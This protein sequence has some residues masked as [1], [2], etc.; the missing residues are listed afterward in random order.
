MRKGVLT[1]ARA[2]NS[3]T[4]P[5]RP[6]GCFLRNSKL[7]TKFLLSLLAITT[8]LT[9]ATLLI[10]RYRVQSRVRESI[11]DDLGHSVNTY[12][13]FEQQRDVALTRSASLIANLPNV[14]ALMT[15]HDEATIQDASYDIQRLSGSDLLVLADRTG[16]VIA[17][18]STRKGFQKPIAQ[19]LLQKSIAAGEAQDF[20]Y[21]GGY[22]YEILIQPIDFGETPNKTNIGLLVV[23][24]EIDS[25]VAKSFGEV[26]ASEVAFRWAG[27]MMA[28]T[29]APGQ[30]QELSRQL[31]A[32]PATAPDTSQEIQL[33]S[34]RYLVTTVSLLSGTGPGVSLSVLR[35]F[36]KATLFLTQLNR[37]LLGLGFLTIAVGTAVG[38]V[39]SDTFT[40]P[41][42]NLVA[43]VQALEKGNYSFPLQGSGRDEVAV[44]TRA[45]G[46]MRDSLQ[47][48]Q[49][50]HKELEERLR[51][52]HKMEAVG[53]LAGGVAHDFNNLLTIIRGHA[54]LLTDRVTADEGSKRNAQQ[55]QKATGRAVSMTRQLL[56]FS[57]M[58]VLQPRIL[59][60]NF[61]VAE[62]GKMLP[63]LIGENI[64]YSFE[65]DPQLANIKADPSQVEQVLLNPAVNARDAMPNGGK[66][67]VKT[68]NVEMEVSAAARRPSMTPGKYV[69]L[70]V[71]DTGDGMDSETKAHIFE[72]FFTTKEVG[73]GT[74]LGLA[75]VYGI[76]KQSG[77]FIWVE[78]SPGTGATFEI[79]FPEESGPA[80][81]I[82]KVSATK[83]R[84]RGSET[85]L[86]VE[87]ES[88][89][90]DL[91]CQ[92]LRSSGYTVL[93]AVDGVEAL[94]ISA[95]YSGT[96]HLLLS[97]MIMPRMGG[98]EL[99]Q[100]IRAAR[101]E[102]K[103]VL[104]SGYAEYAEANN[105]KESPQVPRIQKP[106][107]LTSLAEKVRKVLTEQP[108]E[109]AGR[110]G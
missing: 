82:E 44:V 66:L 5:P 53:R 18:R 30:Q 67:T 20:W 74:G 45:F 96:I 89:V 28:S 97:D 47:K 102:T 65:P 8:G 72:P 58:Q 15:T 69:L 98:A 39:L 92:F 76:V 36:D 81:E 59:D 41:L 64:E 95:R 105:G 23:G 43:G 90:R 6:Y 110:R 100:R 22:L 71:S 63:R 94:E 84:P 17:V 31:A 103:V 108:A 26:A 4:G 27:I 2:R 37:I 33:G 55:I 52:A 25:A 42:G 77:G 107:S 106:F 87:D 21:G 57:R 75:T 83:A 16:I 7:R 3:R 24:H 49:L 61:V 54:D 70:S 104:M 35:S 40:R 12:K 34:E 79:Y 29:F 91:A 50:E 88:G 86:L 78:S 101:P 1:G 11:R 56:A 62:M 80:S 60:L 14:R 51:Q 68:S 99:T 10:V 19:E 85:I 73:K 13:S 93:E 48:G 46:R 32:L 109:Q 9:T 38:F